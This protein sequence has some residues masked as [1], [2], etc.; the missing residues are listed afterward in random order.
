[1][2]TNMN[3]RIF[4]QSST[5]GSAGLLFYPHIL[6]GSPLTADNADKKTVLMGGVTPISII[7][8]ACIL[9]FSS[10]RLSVRSQEVISTDIH[11]RGTPGNKGRLAALMPV[12]DKGLI[13]LIYLLKNDSDIKYI[14][15]KRAIVYGWAAIN[16]VHRIINQ[17][18]EGKAQDQ[19]MEIR[20]HQDALVIQGLSLPEYEPA[21]ANQAEVEKLLNSMLVRTITRAHTMKPDTD[22]GIGWVNRMAAWRRENS[23]YMKKFSA[24]LI[25]PDE[26][27]AGAD[28]FN[29][30]DKITSMAIRLQ[31]SQ[32]VDPAE[33]VDIVDQEANGQFGKALTEATRQIF[34][35]DAFL[36]DKISENE[37]IKSLKL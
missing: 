1:M 17:S 27:V 9:A 28:F 34:S 6:S 24:I 10:G 8:C 23:N 20:M 3:R 4:L 35:I 19:I 12:Q 2:K 36:D 30:N 15:E 33:I 13:E 29:K 5:L 18:L 26:E 11:L 16:S 7:D 25:A 14:K 31:K 21:K 32:K 37:L 22:D